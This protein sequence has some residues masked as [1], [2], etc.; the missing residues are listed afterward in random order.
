V[1]GPKQD[2]ANLKQGILSIYLAYVLEGK[3]VTVKGSLQRVRDMVIVDDVCEAFL[4]AA[5][6]PRTINR[7]F[8]VCTGEGLTIH[9]IIQRL[10]KA[11]GHASYPVI[12]EDGTPGDQFA[13]TGDHTALTE[14]IGWKPT[15]Y[16]DQGLAMI[17]AS[18]KK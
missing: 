10:G 16:L 5:K 1:Y 8:N 17:A 13:S 14:L 6:E 12:E 15:V 3:P 2:L 11:F 18:F 7:A 4:G 9:E